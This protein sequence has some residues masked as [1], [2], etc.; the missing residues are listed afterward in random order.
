MVRQF[1]VEHMQFIRILRA[2]GQGEFK[3]DF[4]GDGQQDIGGR[5]TTSGMWGIS[6][7]GVVSGVM[8]GAEPGL[9]SVSPNAGGAGL[10]DIAIRSSQA[11]VPQ[12]V[13]LPIWGP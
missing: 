6:L 1:I 7:G 5:H 11:G 3:A 2:M 9:D 4:T 8:A 10:T 12:A 13:I